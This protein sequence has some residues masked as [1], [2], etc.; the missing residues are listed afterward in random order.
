MNKYK[1]K[2]IEL[3]TGKE[4]YGD[5]A[6]FIQSNSKKKEKAM[7]VSHYCHGGMLWI[8]ERHLIDENTI[9]PIIKTTV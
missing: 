3:N 9:E 4:V 5:L 6:Y 2:A 1:F 7:R 8:A